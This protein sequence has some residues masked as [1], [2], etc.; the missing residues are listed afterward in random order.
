MVDAHYQKQIDGLE[1]ERLDKLLFKGIPNK[2]PNKHVYGGH[3]IGQSLDACQRTVESQY[4]LHSMHAYFMRLGNSE[5]PI[6][7]EVDPI[8]DGRSFCTRRVNAIQ[9]GD[10]IFTAIMSFHIEETGLEHQVKMP[11]VPPPE[12]L[13]DDHAYYHHVIDQMGP[14]AEPL[15]KRI[16]KPLVPFEMR[17]YDRVEILNPKP[18]DIHGGFWFKLRYDGDD[19]RQNNIRLLAYLSD[20]GLIAGTFR[21]HG[22]VPFDPRIK[23]I[24]SLDHALHLHSRN[25]RV[26]EWMFNAIEGTWTGGARALG[27]G[28]IFTRDGT[29]VA[30]IQQEGLLRVH[31]K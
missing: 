22:F 30:S 11:D 25:F 20:M 14:K 1:L 3:V 19:D 18:K 24:C 21:P 17:S 27:R 12:E 31:E 7:Y 13:I 5:I 15:R 6:I 23:N 8:R 26:D 29:L 2:W 10:A 9:N 28:H 16:E 4:Q